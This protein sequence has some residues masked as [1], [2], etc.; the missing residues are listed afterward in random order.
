MYTRAPTLAGRK[1]HFS[2]RASTRRRTLVRR[3]PTMGGSHQ[4]WRQCA[5][6]WDSASGTSAR[7]EN[8]EGRFGDMAV[9]GSF[10]I[11][12]RAS[13]V[14]SCNK[15]KFFFGSGSSCGNSRW[16]LQR[17]STNVRCSPSAP[18][19]TWDASCGNSANTWRT[20]LWL[21]KCLVGGEL[22]L[23]NYYNA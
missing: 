17:L 22:W 16:C 18:T 12:G 5:R 8:D 4:A 19:H 21:E 3:L 9:E 23:V 7:K 10:Y 14:F 20:Q 6:L 15:N 11:S 13:R 1:N 2:S